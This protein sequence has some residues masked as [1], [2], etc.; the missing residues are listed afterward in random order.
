MTEDQ[1]TG[2]A[3]IDRGERLAERIS[4]SLTANEWK[5]ARFELSTALDD[6]LVG[7][8]TAALG[9][10]NM[11]ALIPAAQA[12]AE[13]VRTDTEALQKNAA[14]LVRA[15]IAL[16]RAEMAPVL[17]RANKLV[18]QILDAR[19]LV[20]RLLHEEQAAH[21]RTRRRLAAFRGWA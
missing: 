8:A 3:A 7:I 2:L 19:D 10:R 16:V 1:T 20:A 15:E 21:A 13:R 11:R 4:R 17:G 18:A 9:Y 5:L 14:E 6:E 12:E